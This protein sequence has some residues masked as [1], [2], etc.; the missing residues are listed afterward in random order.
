M[1]MACPPASPII[2]TVSST[3][4]VLRSTAS[5]WAPSL[6][7]SRAD[8]RPMPLPAPVTMARLPA[9]RPFEDAFMGVSRD[10][11][12]IS[13]PVTARP[14]SNVA[15]IG[16]SP[17]GAPPAAPARM[18][19]D[20]E[21][22]R[23][24]LPHRPAPARARADLPRGPDGRARGVARHADARP[25]LH[26]RPAA[27]AD[28]LRSRGGRLSLR[29]GARRLAIRTARTVVQRPGD[30]RAAHHAP[31]A[32]G[33]RH[34]RTAGAPRPAAH[35]AA[36]QPARRNERRRR[37]DHA[38]GARAP[39]A[40]PAGAPA[41]LRA[42]RARAAQ[43]A[44]PRDRL[45]RPRARRPFAPPHLAP[46]PDTIPQRVVPGRLVPCDGLPEGV[47]AGRHRVGARAV[48]A[49]PRG[50]P[51]RYSRGRRGRLRHLSGRRAGRGGT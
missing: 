26:A 37:R 44:P 16:G 4:S 8:A 50:A 33:S 38:A 13:A 49:R 17:V 5:T 30:P 45:L 29:A 12:T 1:A 51:R 28:R 46:A 31:H 21:P 34:R 40:E 27:R 6:A 35:R 9:S 48:Q 14:G 41:A 20:D 47:R 36:A 15:G 18:T 2:C 11:A 24:L 10:V 39:R 42:D 7:K 3:P 43:A 22:D 23:A 19:R 25:E 32:G